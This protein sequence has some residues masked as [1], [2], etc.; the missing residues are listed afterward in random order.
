MELASILRIDCVYSI[1]DQ[2]VVPGK[3]LMKYNNIM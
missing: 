1:L 3:S 2:Y